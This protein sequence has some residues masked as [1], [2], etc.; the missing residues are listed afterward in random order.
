MRP[1]TLGVASSTV[2]LRD[3]RPPGAVASASSEYAA[4]SPAI[5][6][7]MTTTWGLT[8]TGIS[9]LFAETGGG[10]D[11]TSQCRHHRLFIVEGSGS[12]EHQ[13]EF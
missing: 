6:A 5:P 9:E 3:E 2:T 11:L 1:P 7:P 13:T 8:G 4:V 10:D 12:G